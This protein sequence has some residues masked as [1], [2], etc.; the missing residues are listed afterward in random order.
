MSSASILYTDEFLHQYRNRIDWVA[1][2]KNDS[3]E[4]DEDLYK[5]FEKEL[6]RVKFVD[7]L[8]HCNTNRKILSRNKAE[9]S[10]ALKYDAAGAVVHRTNKAHP[11]ARF[12]FRPK[13]PTQF[14][15]ECLGWDDT[16]LTHWSKPKSYYSE[17]CNLHLPKCPLPV[18]FEFD[19]CEIIAK[20][21]EKC[22]YSNGNMQTNFASVYKIDVDPTRIRTQYLYNDISD[23]FYM[24]DWHDDNAQA[25]HRS[26]I[27]GIKEQSQQEF[28]VMDE[29]DFSKLDSLKIFCYD[30]FQKELLIKYLGDD[31]IVDRIEVNH[32]MYSYDKRSLE[33]SEDDN[34]ITISSDYD[35]NGCAYILV[36]GGSIVNKKAIKNEISSG[37]IIYPSV[38]F[39][40]NN[41]PSEI[42]LVDPNPRADTKQWLIY[43]S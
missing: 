7:I 23:A 25:L 29:L 22:Y 35:L 24:V 14:Y 6:N 28:L 18:F 17:A 19:I 2:S 11:Y 10:K 27:G 1:F 3:V 30:E 20:M 13:S 26:Y 12:Y 16:L 37:I 21:P 31:E 34:S 39:N 40:K 4:I 15:N 38:T 36:K 42:Y 41:P 8:T 32:A 33:M 9:E 43:K 5:D